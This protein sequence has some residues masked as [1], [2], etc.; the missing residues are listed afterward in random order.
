MIKR[1]AL[2]LTFSVALVLGF[3]SAASAQAECEASPI[4]DTCVGVLPLPTEPTG[5][6]PQGGGTPPDAGTAAPSNNPVSTAVNAPAQTLPV[7]GAETAALA[8]GGLLLV[9]AGGALVWRS[10]RAAA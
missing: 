6:T 9:S 3:G 10:N 2:T 4:P 1:S 7:T 5:N 8:L